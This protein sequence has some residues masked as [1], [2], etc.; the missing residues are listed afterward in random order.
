MIALE[1]DRKTTHRTK[2]TLS[3]N[4][5]ATGTIRPFDTASDYRRSLTRSMSIQSATIHGGD[6]NA[7]SMTSPASVILPTSISEA[8]AANKG[9]KKKGE[10]L[11]EIDADFERILNAFYSYQT[12]FTDS[13]EKSLAFITETILQSWQSDDLSMGDD[14]VNLKPGTTP[15]L[16][17][18]TIVQLRFE[19]REAHDMFDQTD[20]RAEKV[21]LHY[22]EALEQ[23]EQIHQADCEL[24]DLQQ[25]KVD[26]LVDVF[27][28]IDNRFCQL[29]VD[30]EELIGQVEDWRVWALAH[31]ERLERQQ[32][33]TTTAGTDIHSCISNLMH[34][35]AILTTLPAGDPVLDLRNDR[36]RLFRD[37]QTVVHQVLH[38]ANDND[39]E[40]AALQQRWHPVEQLLT[41]PAP[42]AVENSSMESGKTAAPTPWQQQLLTASLYSASLKGGERCSLNELE[43][44]FDILN[45]NLCEIQKDLDDLHQQSKQVMENKKRMYDVCL[46]L[47]AEL[48]A[49]QHAPAKPNQGDRTEDVVRREL[50][51]VMHYTCTLFDRQS[52]LDQEAAALKLEQEA[53]EQQLEETKGALRQVRPPLLLQGLLERLETDDK[54]M[55]RVEKDWQEDANLVVTF[56]DQ[57]SIGG[58]EDSNA[59]SSPS[60]SSRSGEQTLKSR[61]KTALATRCLI[62]R[63]D[64]SLYCLKVL[65][66]HHLSRSRQ[67]LVEVQASLSQAKDEVEE[68]HNQMITLYTDA[69]EVARQVYVFK[70]EVEMIIR[71]RKEEVVKV[72]EVV[73]EV[74][75]GIDTSTVP[76]AD[77]RPPPVEDDHE[78]HQW[79][80][81]ELERFQVVHENLQDAI[82][83]LKREQADIGHR[84]REMVTLL[85]EPQVER[86][87]GDV[88]LLSLSD[89]LADLMDGV[90]MH[91]LGLKLDEKPSVTR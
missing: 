39:E 7:P 11:D 80:L 51:Q 25:D 42:I 29:E 74:S 54:P 8:A 73:D 69:A 21:M 33:S 13:I 9:L 26:K 75:V 46:A 76:A 91:D 37:L 41:A 59:S 40:R 77:D 83:D 86:L 1:K 53:L 4:I 34:T 30:Q 61:F 31:L 90:R 65:A 55:V 23:V 27:E 5:T 12:T 63:L 20:Q 47:E 58:D 43:L 56:M 49:L 18:R 24:L 28:R 50:N 2:S 35:L 66:A 10:V 22:R 87:V 57:D 85:I 67:S 32:P 14:K 72:W 15:G 16:L 68:A 36:H 38:D 71:H 52:S 88:S 89:S 3:S 64:A 44:S 17:E 48:T 45:T 70:T 60:L 82:E 62:S 84:I 78:R 6:R 81:R 19:L 79:I